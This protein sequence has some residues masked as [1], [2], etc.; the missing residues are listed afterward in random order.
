[1]LELLA[2]LVPGLATATARS[3]VARA[4]GIPL[5]AVETVRMLVADGRLRETDG[6][7]E[8]VGELGELAVP[9]TLQA[10]IAARLDGLPAADRA[11]LQDAAVLG[12]SFTL[13]GLCAVTG[14]P[15]EVVEPR[16]RVLGDMELL[17]QRVDPRSP[18]LGQYAFVQAL[19]R[20]VAYTT[21]AKR[22]RR[23]RHLAA[24][25]FFESLGED[26]LAGALAAHYVAAYEAVPDGPEG[27]ALAVQARLALVGAADRALALG[28]PEQALTFLTQA[29]EIK[30]EP[31]DRAAILERLG[32]AATSAARPDLAEPPLTEAIEIRRSLGDEKAVY[33]TTVALANGLL[34]GR[35]T[36]RASAILEPAVSKGQG[37]ADDADL[38][39]LIAIL[40]RVRA[41][42]QRY[43]EALALA[44]RALEIAEP[45]ELFEVV[46]EFL[47]SKG[48]ILSQHGRTVEGLSLLDTARRLAQENGL[49]LMESRA[50]T[51]LSLVLATRDVRA[52]WDMEVEGIAFARRIG[53]RDFEITLISNASEDAVRLGEWTWHESQAASFEDTELSTLHRLAIGFAAAVIATLRGDPGATDLVKQVHVDLEVAGDTDY[54]NTASD[55]DAWVAM[56]EGRYPAARDDW[57]KQAEQSDTNAPFALP[58]AA[59]A[60]LLARDAAGAREAIAR[61]DAMG[62]RGQVLDIERQAIGAGI[63]ALEG[64]TTEAIAGFRA[65]M[66]AWRD[67]GVLW[68]EA[69]T[70]WC[71]LETLG[72]DQAEVRKIGWR[73]REIAVELGAAPVV[74]H[75]D[76]LLGESSGPDAHEGGAATAGAAGA[77]GTAEVAK[78]A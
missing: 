76:A 18:E 52:T 77:P 31:A 20:E 51:G 54:S 60:A 62:V 33:R 78:L 9:E 43:F 71:A 6:R 38:A 64:R 28:S 67:G 10:L 29:K 44:D 66:A 75:L 39:Q 23:S 14:Q 22:D 73:G 1:M 63:D 3:I 50:I 68:D 16:L 34:S 40:S 45:L 19:I 2:G 36:E 8:P 12:Q 30:A 5:Y 48:N 37:V 53:R 25:R 27:D 21:L 59:R 13:A 49:P 70:A 35:L 17:D 24:A 69:W 32:R 15:P 46:A 42:E 55:L 7:Y 26:E 56:V 65:A 58:R 4:D 61:L 47:I 57:F 74:A 41:L 11:L 72:S